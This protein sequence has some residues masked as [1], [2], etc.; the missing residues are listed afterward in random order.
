MDVQMLEEQKILAQIIHD[1][2]Y[3][4]HFFY[5]QMKSFNWLSLTLNKHPSGLKKFNSDLKIGTNKKQVAGSSF[6]ATL[7]SH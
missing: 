5:C 1:N 7:Q 6:Q 2:T 3:P 4:W